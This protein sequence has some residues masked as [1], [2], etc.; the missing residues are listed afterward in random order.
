MQKDYIGPSEDT[1]LQ[2]LTLRR[3]QRL[4]APCV[5]KEGRNSGCTVDITG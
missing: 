4:G 2:A 3:Q 5:E 1:P